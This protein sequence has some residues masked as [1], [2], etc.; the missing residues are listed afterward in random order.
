MSF[1]YSP[2]GPIK[3]L[4]KLQEKNALG[5]YLLLLAH[6]VIKYEA[7]YVFLL[8]EMDHPKDQEGI[9]IAELV[10]MDNGVIELGKPMPFDQVVEAADIATAECIVMPDV[11]GDFYATRRAVEAEWTKIDA[12]DYPIMKVPQG[13]TPAEVIK[14]IEW[15]IEAIPTQYGHEDYW[16]IPRWIA[17][18]LKTRTT[19]IDYLNHACEAPQIHLLGMSKNLGDDILCAHRDNVMGIDSANPIVFGLADMYLGVN[20]YRHL[21]R[22]DY[23]DKTDINYNVLRNIKYVRDTFA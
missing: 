2:I 14:C 1:R 18:K 9:P 3:I 10:I 16:G 15:L 22:G 17:N 6:D 19:F 12:S 4:Q 11:L 7:D 8:D 23:W 20:R 21:D 5:N 13:S